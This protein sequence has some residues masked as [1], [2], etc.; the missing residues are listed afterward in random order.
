MDFVHGILSNQQAKSSNI[1]LFLISLK[2][3]RIVFYQFGLFDT[4]SLDHL[5]PPV[6]TLKNLTFVM[7]N[8][9]MS[10]ALHPNFYPVNLQHT[11]C[12]QVLSISR[13]C[14]CVDPDKIASLEGR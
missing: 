14:E 5:F 10:T 8:I 13:K 9:L 11:S 7:L 3:P 4:I 2:K 1:H 12:K 6:A